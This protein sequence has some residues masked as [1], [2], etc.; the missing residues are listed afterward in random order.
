MK[1]TALFG[2]AVYGAVSLLAKVPDFL[3]RLDPLHRNHSG[4]LENGITYSINSCN[5]SLNEIGPKRYVIQFG[6]GV[7]VEDVRRDGELL[8]YD[9]NNHKRL[10][11]A[12]QAI[13]AN[14][15]QPFADG[16]YVV[17]D[18]K[19]AEVVRRVQEVFDKEKLQ[20]KAKDAYPLKY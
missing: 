20:I 13:F 16:T 6:D 3:D 9:I 17:D 12:S 19:R 5:D 11:I 7:N 14:G 15:H 8:C 10:R 2:L 18:T 1:K 4:Q